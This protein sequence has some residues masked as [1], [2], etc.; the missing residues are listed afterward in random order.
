MFLGHVPRFSFKYFRWPFNDLDRLEPVEDHP[1]PVRNQLNTVRW[2][3]LDSCLGDTSFHTS[4]MSSHH[5]QIPTG[6]SQKN[7][8]LTLS[9]ISKHESHRPI[10][11]ADGHHVAANRMTFMVQASCPKICWILED[12]YKRC[13]I[14]ANG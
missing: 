9:T 5:D 6:F 3:Q 11:H 13:F 10:H 4:R 7:K 1:V 8:T 12:S 14:F 2:F